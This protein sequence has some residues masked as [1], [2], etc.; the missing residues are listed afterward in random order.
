MSKLNVLHAS[1]ST[2]LTDPIQIVK[3]IYMVQKRKRRKEKK[4]DRFKFSTIGDISEIPQKR[5]SQ[6]KFWKL[7]FSRNL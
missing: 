6:M 2:R 5:G 4:N 7:I 3:L 1:L